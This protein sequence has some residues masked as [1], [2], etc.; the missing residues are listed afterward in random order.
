MGEAGPTVFR[1]NRRRIEQGKTRR[2][3]QASFR[4]FPQLVPVS[5][6]GDRQYAEAGLQLAAH[7][8]C[9]VDRDLEG[10]RAMTVEAGSGAG[11]VPLSSALQPGAAFL[12]LATLR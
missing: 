9:A 12:N 5:L 4:G 1:R 8:R 10:A 7:D 3:G 11:A 2:R 6:P